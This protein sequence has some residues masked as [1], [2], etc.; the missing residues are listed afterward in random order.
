MDNHQ[1]FIFYIQMLVNVCPSTAQQARSSLQAWRRD[2]LQDA[3]PPPISAIML[4]LIETNA[5]EKRQIAEP[6][7]N[8][9]EA[10]DCEVN[11]SLLRAKDKSHSLATVQLSPIP[12]ANMQTH[13]QQKV[14]TLQDDKSPAHRSTQPELQTA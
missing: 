11:D 1:G 6:E 7:N 4:G 3:V 2:G 8:Q 10:G 14:H 5:T 9:T 13:T 12:T